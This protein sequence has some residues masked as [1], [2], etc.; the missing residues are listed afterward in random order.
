M[1]SWLTHLD[2]C[3]RSQ[4]PELPPSAWDEAS[5]APLQK[6]ASK[7][8]PPAFRDFLLWRPKDVSVVFT[9]EL[10]G[11][12][13][14]HMLELGEIEEIVTAWNRPS[15]P[16]TRNWWSP[17]WIPMLV[18]SE[19][20]ILCVDL[21]GTFGNTSGSLLQFLPDVASRPVLFPHVEGWL[22]W[23][24]LALEQGMGRAFLE[25]NR[26]DIVLNRKAEKLHKDFFPNYPVKC[27][28]EMLGLGFMNRVLN[29]LRR[30]GLQPSANCS[31][32]K[33][34]TMDDLSSALDGGLFREEGADGE[35][36]RVSG[37]C[38]PAGQM[39]SWMV[40]GHLKPAPNCA[41]LEAVVAV[42]ENAGNDIR[43]GLSLVYEHGDPV[44]GS[45]R[46]SEAAYICYQAGCGAE[47]M[48]LLKRALQ[49][50]PQNSVAARSL[51]A[52]ELKQINS[53]YA[54]I[55]PLLLHIGASAP[56]L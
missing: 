41:L 48:A 20:D 46:L 28:P 29:V 1:N 56:L 9:W 37:L 32:P 6:V 17:L 34:L 23:L 13:G 30:H 14:G 39:D 25:H 47:A 55:R 42:P 38:Q 4:L 33:S 44:T 7:A 24:A 15:P 5:L 40:Y 26:L 43:N 2:S 50:D 53:D 16:G 27:F 31:L 19:G 36:V 45:R 49:W 35:A 8:L 18:G 3:L 52:L 10:P 22:R 54:R 11:S 51:A 21:P 12:T